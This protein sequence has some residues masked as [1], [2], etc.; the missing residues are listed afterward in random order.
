MSMKRA[1]LSS[2]GLLV[3]LGCATT[4]SNVPSVA[5]TYEPQ[6]LPAR[7]S[8]S[9]RACYEHPDT[10]KYLERLHARV[11]DAWAVPEGT[12][13]HEIRASIAL[14][15]AG[16]A[17]RVRILESPDDELAAEGSSGSH[18]TIRRQSGIGVA[19]GSIERLRGA[20]ATPGFARLHER[21]PY[22]R[23][24]RVYL[25]DR[26]PHRPPEEDRARGRVLAAPGCSRARARCP[27]GATARAFIFFVFG[28]APIGGLPGLTE[29]TSATSVLS[30][31][32]G[33]RGEVAAGD[34]VLAQEDRLRGSATPTHRHPGTSCRRRVGHP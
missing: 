14:D 9:V 28:I 3:A 12:S 22:L 19:G 23:R 26:R 10:P 8:E 29:G 33:A 16:N 25:G 15:S 27:P 21:G 2:L 20:T 7:A 4:E 34:A 1:V 30:R 18:P 11:I 24:A 31:R 6:P 32:P 13:G 17:S 5:R